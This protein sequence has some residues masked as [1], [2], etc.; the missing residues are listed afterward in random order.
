MLGS[1]IGSTRPFSRYKKVVRGAGPQTFESEAAAPRVGT[2]ETCE[3]EKQLS[4]NQP[5]GKARQGEAR[6]G[7]AS[8][9]ERGLQPN[10]YL[11]ESVTGTQYRAIVELDEQFPTAEKTFMHNCRAPKR[12]SPIALVLGVG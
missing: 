1:T 12:E 2:V 6:Q 3:Q 10:L 7:E 11:S 4:H 9:S 5:Q 8:I